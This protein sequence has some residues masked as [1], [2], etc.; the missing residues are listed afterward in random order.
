MGMGV[1]LQR[2]YNYSVSIYVV[3]VN[4]ITVIK[5]QVN[6][7]KFIIINNEKYIMTKILNQIN[8]QGSYSLL[9][10]IFNSRVS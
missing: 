8:K 4:D 5:E 1:S 7:D 2:E 3:E 10:N 9:I 6:D